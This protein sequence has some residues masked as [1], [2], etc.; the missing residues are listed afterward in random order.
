MGC[1]CAEI[2]LRVTAI[3]C[4]GQWRCG[5]GECG[6]KYYGVRGVG[7]VCEMCMCL[8]RAECEVLRGE[9]GE[10]IGFCFTN[11]VGTWGVLDVCLCLG[12]VGVGGVGGVGRRW[13]GGLRLGM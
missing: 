5:F 13:V 2:V 3:L 10:R 12:C 6:V 4:G 8:T 11:P 7:G 1:K 9:W